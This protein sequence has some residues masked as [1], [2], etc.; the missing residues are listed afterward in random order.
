MKQFLRTIAALILCLT[1]CIC[2]AGA[3]ADDDRETG[4]IDSEYLTQLFDEYLQSNGI[5]SS[6]GIF[7]V[8]FTYTATGDSWYY[9][10]DEW[11]YS[12]SLYKVPNCM[13]LAEQEAAGLIT[14]DSTVEGYTVSY[15]EYSAIVNSNND[16]G[17]AIV[18]Y[19]GGTYNGKCS[20]QFIEY[21]TL[22]ESYF[23][24]QDFYDYSYYTARFM[25][26]VINTLYN[27][28]DRFPNIIDLMKQTQPNNY[29]HLALGDT[30]E[31]AQ[32]YGA[33]QEPN[34]TQDNH[35]SGIIYTPNP[36]IVTVMTK[37]VSS[38]ELR[39]AEAAQMLAEYALTLDAGLDD[40]IANRDAAA[41]Q[42]PETEEQTPVEAETQTVAQQEAEPEQTVEQSTP[43]PADEQIIE[44]PQETTI[45]ESKK[46]FPVVP[47]LA[48]AV[49]ILAVA[50]LIISR[51]LKAAEDESYP[52]SSDW[53]YEP[54]TGT[55]AGKA[56]EKTPTKKSK[57][58][59]KGYTPKH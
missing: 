27:E 47:L 18:D 7:S 22:P 33:Y 13:K 46:S 50:A 39:I 59:S 25:N 56:K 48:G 19:L 5:T 23:T 20:D 29:F 2:P 53:A 55:A 42:A 3:Y 15:L 28:S 38:F 14:Q 40:Y 21:T 32:K 34:G 51:K 36:I 41:Q 11:M 31:I 8:A 10:A 43:E 49:I 12:A 45:K 24:N 35:C 30:Y 4:I 37:N 52:D 57:T 16:S 26:Q 17:H 54:E 9:N 58:N 6:G 44:Q 1:V